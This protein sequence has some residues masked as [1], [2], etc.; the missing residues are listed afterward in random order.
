MQYFQQ[1]KISKK[2]FLPTRIIVLTFILIITTLCLAGFTVYKNIFS[3]PPKSEK[4]VLYSIEEDKYSFINPATGE[5]E[6]HVI[7]GYK[8]IPA[9]SLL[10]GDRY[11]YGAFPEFFILIK[12]DELFSYSLINGSIK[13]ISIDPLKPSEKIA[14]YPSI[15]EKNK[16]YIVI[17]TGE[18]ISEFIKVTSLRRYFFDANTHQVQLVDKEAPF[19]SRNCYVFDSKYQRVFSSTCGELQSVIPFDVYDLTTKAQQHI[20]LPQDFGEKDVLVSPSIQ[21]RYSNGYFVIY[22]V[23]KINKIVIISPDKDIAKKV[24]TVSEAIKEE[25]N[26]KLDN[27]IYF[28]FSYE[29]LFLK[30]RNTIVLA[31]DAREDTGKEDFILLLRFNENNQI[32]DFKYIPVSGIMFSMFS[33][34]DKLYIF[35]ENSIQVINL[36]NWQVEKVIPVKLG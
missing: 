2:H 36:E 12:D 35:L 5:I 15:S 29:A 30:D 14:I 28:E 34:N 1:T 26:K 10:F 17:Y 22:P 27:I 9:Y 4:K 7:S 19:D 6:T 20:A 3:K 25:L 31:A 8:I 24:L 16:F 23:G 13:K 21:V 32:I 11:S 18:I 33:Q